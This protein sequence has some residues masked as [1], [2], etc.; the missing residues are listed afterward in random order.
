MYWL[1]LILL[2]IPFVIMLPVKVYGKKNFNKKQKYI[3][4]FKNSSK[5]LKVFSI[6]TAGI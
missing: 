4:V 2:F 6:I 3:V 1:A 5:N